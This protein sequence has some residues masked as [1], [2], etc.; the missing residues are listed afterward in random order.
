MFGEGDSSVFFVFF[1]LN[2]RKTLSLRGFILKP[3]L[4][5]MRRAIAGAPL[6]TPKPLETCKEKHALFD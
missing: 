1:Y 5:H 6:H 3:R 2:T 4:W